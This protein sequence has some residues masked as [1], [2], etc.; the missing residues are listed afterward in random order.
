MRDGGGRECARVCVLEGAKEA[1]KRPGGQGGRARTSERAICR[2]APTRL[3]IHGVPSLIA[4]WSH[5]PTQKQHRSR[6]SMASILKDHGVRSSVKSFKNPNSP[7]FHACALSGLP[8]ARSLRRHPATLAWTVARRLF[9]WRLRPWCPAPTHAHTHPCAAQQ[10]RGAPRAMYSQQTCG[11][12]SRLSGTSHTRPGVGAVEHGCHAVGSQDVQRDLRMV[13]RRVGRHRGA[14]RHSARQQ[15]RCCQRVRPSR[16]VA[17]HGELAH[18][19]SVCEDSAVVGKCCVAVPG[20]RAARRAIAGPIH[21][22]EADPPAVPMGSRHIPHLLPSAHRTPQLEKAATPMIPAA[23][24]NRC[25]QRAKG[26]Y[27]TSSETSVR[28]ALTLLQPTV[29]QHTT[30][31]SDAA[32]S[33]RAR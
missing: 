14:R 7:C 5:A 26:A 22:D 25:P 19:E 16:A 13:V 30:Q 28:G 33:R 8:S 21:R 2:P 31:V 11:W 4:S 24:H 20:R 12:Q 18:P 32:P 6:S 15:G 17:E 23:W 9:R 1:A 3:C 10:P 27:S 29:P